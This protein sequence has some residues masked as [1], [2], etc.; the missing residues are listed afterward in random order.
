M[1]P[2]EFTRQGSLPVA[3]HRL[4]HLLERRAGSRLNIAHLALGSLRVFRDQLLSQFAF[5]R[6]QRET[7]AQQ[8]MQIAGKAQALLRDG[9]AGDLPTSQAQFPI[10]AKGAAEDSNGR[11]D[12]RDEK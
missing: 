8:I 5:E 7:P 12:S 2:L 3:S 6:N 1:C 10:R 11:S 4:A 9:Q